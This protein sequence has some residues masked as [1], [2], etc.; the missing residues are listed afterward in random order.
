MR[1]LR[2]LAFAVLGGLVVAGAFLALGVTGRRSTQTVVEEAPVAA[3]PVSSSSKRLTPHSLYERDAPGVVFIRAQ[4]RRPVQGPFEL[5]GAVSQGVSTGSGFLVGG[6]GQIL[7][8][9]DVVGGADPDDGVTVHFGDGPAV[10]ATVLE[11]DP[12]EDVAVLKVKPRSL[13]HLSPLPLG[14]STTVR[15]GDPALAIA[16]PFGSDRTLSS[17]IVSALQ[18]ELPG[19]GGANMS[20]VIE[21]EMPVYPGSSGGPLLDAGGRVIGINSQMRT[22]GPRG[23]PGAIAFAIPID[24]AKALLDRLGAGR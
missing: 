19:P 24:T 3:Q 13:P 21:T 4:Q 11:S 2:P 6:A 18:S 12:T 15:V 20:N 16:N 17:G 14:D 9:Y 22:A 1:P 8:T 23:V 5:R 7:T 10:R